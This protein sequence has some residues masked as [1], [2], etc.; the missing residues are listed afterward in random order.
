[1][2]NRSFKIGGLLYIVAICQ[3]FAFELVAETLYH[4]FSVSSNYISDLC[5]T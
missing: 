3:F 2:R 1:V 5:T 4:G